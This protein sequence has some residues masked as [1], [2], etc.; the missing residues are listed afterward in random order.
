ME[1][2]C[3]VGGNAKQCKCY[4]KK[5]SMVVSAKKYKTELPHD[6][7]VHILKRI[8]RHLQTHL[9]S[10]I[11]TTAKERKATHIHQQ[12]NEQKS[13]KIHAVKHDLAPKRK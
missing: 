13:W 1:A 7:A 12:M 8:K 4:K 11:I 10:S 3:T 6:P 2:L 9:H 5:N